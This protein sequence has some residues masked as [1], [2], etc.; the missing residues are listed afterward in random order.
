MLKKAQFYI[1]RIRHPSKAKP[2][3][4]AQRAPMLIFTEGELGVAQ[5]RS[6]QDTRK[7]FELSGNLAEVQVRALSDDQNEH[8]RVFFGHFAVD[9]L[10]G[11][12]EDAAVRGLVRKDHVHD[13]HGHGGSSLPRETAGLE[14]TAQS[15]PPKAR[16]ACACVR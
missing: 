6:V 12:L 5:L 9:G 2:G 10:A 11:R 14:L 7:G 1:R 16:S 4:A 13:R 3:R 15:W 8:V